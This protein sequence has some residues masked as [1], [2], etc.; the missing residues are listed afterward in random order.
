MPQP[1]LSPTLV[2]SIQRSGLNWIR[3]CVEA[4]T[5][6]RTP[7]RVLLVDT[8]LQAPTVFDRSHDALGLTDRADSAPAW[9]VAT[10]HDHRRAL[11]LLRDY[12]ETFVRH[13][14]GDPAQMRHFVGNIRWFDAFEGEKLV[15]WY[16][17]FT[18][19]A[20]ALAPVLRFLGVEPERLEGFDLADHQARSRALY[21]RNQA[22]GGGSMTRADPTNM[23]FHQSRASPADL[24]RWEAWTRAELGPLFDRYLGRYTTAPT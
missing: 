6:R 5:G 20:A 9:V 11:L 13:A 1:Q 23:T 21:D 24:A 10:R 8:P 12:R 16:E 17:D 4:L 14:S 2:V 18:Q 15:A 19:D 22:D 7:G 3:Y